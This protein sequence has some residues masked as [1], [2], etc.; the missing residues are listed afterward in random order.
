MQC[1]SI[2]VFTFTG[3]PSQSGG[4][5]RLSEP[6]HDEAQI[7]RTL[8]EIVDEDNY[9]EFY[10][11][12]HGGAGHSS[13]AGGKYGALG[14]GL[15]GGGDGGDG[16]RGAA[17]G[18]SPRRQYYTAAEQEEVIYEDLCSFKSKSSL[19]LQQQLNF[20]LTEK[21][22]YCIKVRTYI[23]SD[24]KN[25]QLDISSLVRIGARG[26]GGQVRGRVEHAAEE[27]HSDDHVDQGH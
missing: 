13:S 1:E 14:I 27:L 19:Q 8:E 10:Y 17:G 16:V 11:R 15:G 3:F 6:S 9:R 7:Y 26:D 20:K 18:G 21:R 22:D 4:A 12:H 5:G 24:A 2:H 23:S 25:A